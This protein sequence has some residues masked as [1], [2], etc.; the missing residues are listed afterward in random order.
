MGPG[1]GG[2][3]WAGANPGP[4]HRRV[5]GPWP[6]LAGVTPGTAVPGSL[7]TRPR[8]EPETKWLPF[9][10]RQCALLSWGRAPRPPPVTDRHSPSC[11]CVAPASPCL[12][13]VPPSLPTPS[14]PAVQSRRSGPP[15]PVTPAR[16]QMTQGRWS[17]G[18]P[19]GS[20]RPALC[21][22]FPTCV[23]GGECYVMSKCVQGG[24]AAPWGCRRGPVEGE[25]CSGQLG[26]GAMLPQPRQLP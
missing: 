11:L 24:P 6:L 20:D 4:G 3:R 18:L 16:S 7:P 22:G 1:S 17:Q 9:T 21:L 8:L 26:A 19:E 25:V 10:G 14:G 15:P 23:V 2:P 13:A 5:G 12:L